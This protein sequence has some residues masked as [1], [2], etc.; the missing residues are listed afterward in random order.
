MGGFS[1]AFI[2]GGGEEKPEP[3]AAAAKA[4]GS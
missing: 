1:E 2:L 3:P 4:N